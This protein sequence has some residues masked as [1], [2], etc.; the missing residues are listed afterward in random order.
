MFVYSNDGPLISHLLYADDVL[1][2]GEW[3]S[4]N[5]DNLA[6]ILSCFNV[7]SR[8]KVNFNKS[9]VYDIGVSEGELNRSA[10][11]LG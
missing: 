4:S 1:F 2:V 6:R 11:I 8:L 9:Q 7:A 5:F 3:I 10:R